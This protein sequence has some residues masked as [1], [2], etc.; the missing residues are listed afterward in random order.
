MGLKNCLQ[1]R[2]KGRFWPLHAKVSIGFDIKVDNYR[3]NNIKTTQ[4]TWSLLK[5]VLCQ[6]EL[7]DFYIAKDRCGKAIL[8]YYIWIFPPLDKTFIK[9]HWLWYTL[10]D[11]K[12]K[13]DQFWSWMGTSCDLIFSNT[14][15]KS[16]VQDSFWH[17]FLAMRK[18]HHTFWKKQPLTWAVQ[19]ISVQNSQEGMEYT[20]AKE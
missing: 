17:I 6:K 10:L 19:S 2:C 4:N 3:S 18:M 12:R 9:I 7:E 5:V 8:N 20:K 15:S 14:I 11:A 1:V 16:L 13:T